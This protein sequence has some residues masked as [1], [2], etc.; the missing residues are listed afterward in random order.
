[1]N[2]ARSGAVCLAVLAAAGLAARAASQDHEAMR[3]GQHDFDFDLG[4]W[5]THSS[6]LRHPLT[7]SSEWVEMDGVTVVKPIWGGRANLA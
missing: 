5:K 4:K 3:D 7:G 1:M 6:R 2:R